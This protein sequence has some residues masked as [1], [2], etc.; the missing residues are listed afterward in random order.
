MQFFSIQLES[1]EASDVFNVLVDGA[2]VL[3]TTGDDGFIDDLGGLAGLTI[4]AGTEVTFE[5]DG[6]LNG[7][8]GPNT[9]IRIE[10]FTVEIIESDDGHGD[11]NMDGIINFLDISPFI[12]VLS[13]GGSPAAESQADCNGDGT[14]S[15]LDIAPF[16]VALTNAAS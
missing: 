11:V 3:G 5:V 7:T 4:V 6:V 8:G 16:I 13:S 10:S 1:V 9:S 15:F 12:I 14:V 2:L